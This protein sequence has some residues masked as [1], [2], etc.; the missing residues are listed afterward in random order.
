M[1]GAKGV[2]ISIIGGEDMKLL[3][4][5]EAANH[6]REL[7]DPNAN[8]IWGSAFNPDLQ[9][10]IR[11]SVVATGIEQTAAMAEEAARPFALSSASR[12]PAIPA[13]KQ[14]I[15][16]DVPEAEAEPEF[17]PEPA[18]TTS[19]HQD[20]EHGVAH[21]AEDSEHAVVGAEGGFT[22]EPDA[23]DADSD[24]TAAAAGDEAVDDALDLRLELD[25][26]R[27]EEDASY[28][29]EEETEE[30][31]GEDDGGYAS[32]ERLSSFGRR[33]A[34]DDLLETADR[35]N[36]EDEEAA[37]RIARGLGGAGAKPGGGGSVAGATLFERMANLSRGGRSANADD[38]DN[39]ESGEGGGALNIPRFLGR[40]N[41]Q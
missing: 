3:E 17:E 2:I 7:V 18:A 6:I 23:G 36:E 12:G 37:P 24:E 19:W 33:P 20:A 26:G 9:G 27:A 30:G 29:D 13:A 5:D 28:G 35:L 22:G 15:T 21:P 32:L 11:V 25:E 41:N 16:F 1:Q 8:I 40:Q 34:S 31:A 10:K 14:P 4:V 38:E 39:D